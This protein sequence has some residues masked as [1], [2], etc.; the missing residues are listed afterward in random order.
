MLGLDAGFSQ[1]GD[2]VGG[3]WVQ[4]RALPRARRVAVAGYLVALVGTLLELPVLPF[5][6]LPHVAVRVLH[7]TTIGLLVAAAPF[8]LGGTFV[9]LRQDAR[10]RASVPDS[11]GQGA[12]PD[13]R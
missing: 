1:N 5:F 11:A 4:F 10:K 2:W 13:D 8:A 12:T 9:L 3:L 6:G 7:Y